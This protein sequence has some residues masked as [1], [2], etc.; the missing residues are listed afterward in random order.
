MKFF[1]L[2][3]REA[4]TDY[5]T[6]SIEARVAAAGGDATADTLAA[7]EAAAFLYERAFA[8]ADSDVLTPS[9]LALIGRRLLLRGEA[10][11]MVDKGVIGAPAVSWDVTGGH[12]PAKWNYRLDLAAPSGSST[13]KLHSSAVFHPRIGTTPTTPWR[14]ASP[15]GRSAETTR[16]LAAIERQLGDEHGG[17]VGHV[18]PV[19]NLKQAGKLPAAIAALRGKVTLGE[20]SSKGWGE[21]GRPPAGEWHPQRIGASPDPATVE[22]RRDVERTVYSAAGIPAALLSTDSEPSRESWRMF[23]HGTLLPIGRL[24]GAELRSKG[25]GTGQI[26]FDSLMASDLAGRARAYK[27]LTE[28]GMPGPDARRICGFP[29]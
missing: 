9:Q 22:L 12:S 1:G 17:P 2:E 19:P 20:S 7:I 10:V 26:T 5:T 13:V 16:L 8:A 24:L 15:I 4:A 21:G 6:L 11:F 25:L 14:G 28:A 3:V 18:I 27:Q 23:L 29:K